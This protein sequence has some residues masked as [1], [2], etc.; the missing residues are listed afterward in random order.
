MNP[1]L[2]I[3][4]PANTTELIS[5]FLVGLGEAGRWNYFSLQAILFYLLIF[6][7]I[8]AFEISEPK[9]RRSVVR[10]LRRIARSNL[11]FLILII[12]FMMISRVPL[13]A[14]GTTNIDE[15]TWIAIA[16]TLAVD[17]RYWISADGYTGGPL[18]PFTLLS[19]NLFGLPIDSGTLKIMSAL[20][21]SMSIG[22]LFLFLSYFI[23]LGL[24][25]LVILPLAVALAMTDYY[26]MIAYNSEHVVIV[27]FCLSLVFFGKV[28]KTSPGIFY[29][30]VI[31]TGFLLGLVPYAKLQG[32]PIALLLGLVTCYI[33]LKKYTKKSLLFLVFSSI[34]PTFLILITVWSYGGLGDFWI[35]YI[36]G[37]LIY[38]A[39]NPTA[40]NPFSE[41]MS[42]LFNLLFN[43]PV[44]RFF[45]YYS[46]TAIL[47]SIIWIFSF[48]VKLERLE[49]GKFLF[50]LSLLGVSM[51]CV[52]VPNNAFHHYILLVLAPLTIAT[53]TAI[54]TS[55]SIWGRKFQHHN[56]LAAQETLGAGLASIFVLLTSLHY[57]QQHF[58]FRPNYLDFAYKN[59]TKYIHYPEITSILKQYYYPGAR[60]AVWGWSCELY[61]DT[62]MLMGTRY[63]GSQGILEGGTMKEYFTANYLKDLAM[64]SPLL[65]VET[66]G[67]NF[68]A[69]HDENLH[70]VESSEEMRKYIN[71]HYNLWHEVS[72]ARIYVNKS[73]RQL[74][75]LGEYPNFQN[76]I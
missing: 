50:S 42:L 32:A 9:A 12:L 34:A 19:L 74:I 27:I 57:F 76:N 15:N 28:L 26:D 58:T 11:T 52:V 30:N 73:Y 21:M 66:I 64:N 69:Y 7:S 36:E 56:I 47:F 68:R 4:P 2:Q 35:S 72:G 49:V 71:E 48:G 1:C 8:Y 65:F 24:A 39:R 63:T 75:P 60:M 16:K 70:S 37:N 38:A 31:I 29:Q 22:F 25:R 45:L 54:D 51:Y 59:Q 67:P 6:V 40:S 43:P 46:F 44:L 20:L 14:K 10:W 18:V 23:R 53:G 62:G 5:S 3:C 61:E 33:C 41:K 13:A 55:V 17:P